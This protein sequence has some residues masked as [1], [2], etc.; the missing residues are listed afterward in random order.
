MYAYI[1]Q[2]CGKPAFLYDHMPAVGEPV[3]SRHVRTLDG[4]EIEPCSKRVCES[5]GKPVFGKGMFGTNL[6]RK[7]LVEV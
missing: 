3:T 5:C 6:Q 4:K 7:C 2:E 1:H